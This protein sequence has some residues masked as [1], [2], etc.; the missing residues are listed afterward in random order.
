M[1]YKSGDRWV[2][3]TVPE[4]RDTVRWLATALHELGVKPGDRVGI[5]SEN[6]PEWTMADFAILCA[7]ARHAFR[8][9]RRSS[10]GRSSTSSTTPARSRVICSNQEQ[11]DKVLEIRSHVPDAATTSSSAIAPA[12]MPDGVLTFKDVVDARQEVRG[13][14][15][16]EL[17]RAVAQLAQ[18]R[19]PGH[20]RL[21]LRH[22]RQSQGRD[23]HARQHR[24]QRRRPCASSCRSSAGDV[25]LSFLPLSHILERMVDYLYFYKGGCDRLRRERHQSR[26]Q[27]AAR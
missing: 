10:A 9:I 5:L 12:P 3:V 22:H 1:K 2:D 8:S 27:P 6:R 23:A 26:G 17:V 19:R 25:A 11:L 14:A 24:Q 16:A 21:H 7:S 15:T 20:A 4:F 13:E 18:A